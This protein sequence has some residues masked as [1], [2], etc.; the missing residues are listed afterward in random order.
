MWRSIRQALKRLGW[1]PPRRTVIWTAITIAIAACAWATIQR[2]PFDGLTLLAGFCGLL[3]LGML[4]L[5]ARPSLRVVLRTPTEVDTAVVIGHGRQVRALDKEAIVDEQVGAA[6]AT[7]PPRPAPQL[8]PNSPLAKAYSSFA[9][10]AIL[11]GISTVSEERLQES[12]EEVA[13][14]RRDLANWLDELEHARHERLRIFYGAARV[15]E[16]GEAPGDHVRLRLRFPPGFE[17]MTEDAPW[18]ARPPERPNSRPSLPSLINPPVLDRFPTPVI[19]P[20]LTG[21]AAGYS[22]DGEATLVE[23][24]LGRIN[25]SDHRDTAKFE[26]RAAP[27]GSYEVEWEVSA[28]GLRKAARGRLRLDVAEP[29]AA[30]PITTL[31]EVEA[32]RERYELD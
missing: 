19:P 14:Y 9:A 32:E 2:G 18:V 29:Q 25:Q 27:P 24:D 28:S 26:L 21:G 1:P 6:L 31:A 22:R 10:S 4:L 15:Q 23:F 16:G 12:E 5:P 30:A 13:G 8:P 11:G 7:L 20:S 17:P 3:S